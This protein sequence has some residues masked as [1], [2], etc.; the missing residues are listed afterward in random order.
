MASCIRFGSWHLTGANKSKLREKDV[1]KIL[2]QV[3]FRSDADIFALQGLLAP[4]PG[5][6]RSILSKVIDCLRRLTARTTDNCWSYTVCPVGQSSTGE[7]NCVAFVFR[8]PLPEGVE[9]GPDEPEVTTGAQ[10]F[11][12][13]PSVAVLSVFVHGGLRRLA[14]SCVAVPPQPPPGQSLADGEVMLSVFP[15]PGVSVS[16]CDQ[17]KEELMAVSRRCPSSAEGVA[18][19]V[20]AVSH[21]PYFP[22][23]RQLSYYD[24]DDVLEDEDNAARRTFSE[25]LALD[26]TLVAYLSTVA[27]LTKHSLPVSPDFG[28]ILGDFAV[29]HED[30][31]MEPLLLDDFK[32]CVADCH[33]PRLMRKACG[34]DIY[35]WSDQM[36]KQ[37]SVCVSVSVMA[38]HEC[39]PPEMQ[40]IETALLRDLAHHFPLWAEISFIELAEGDDAD[41]S[42]KAFELVSADQPVCVRVDSPPRG[43]FGSF[44]DKLK[45]MFTV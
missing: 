31:H 40:D 13:I 22:H 20:S 36:E 26:R 16:T 37:M 23:P 6:C 32:S 42:A 8:S 35:H 43:L 7:V 17:S 10:G 28:V 19:G 30:V 5:Q 34:S 33:N 29:P 39:L 4:S 18:V 27:S 25:S 2:A 44:M 38:S 41:D 12:D 14:V 45:G 1:S 15:R 21:T 9:I 11:G 24:S 3:I